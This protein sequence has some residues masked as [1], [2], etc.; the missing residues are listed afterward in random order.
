MAVIIWKELDMIKFTINVAPV[1]KKNHGQIIIN[2]KTGRPMVIPSPQYIQYEKDCGWFMPKVETIEEPV[3]VKAVFYMATKRKVDLVNLQEA[4]LD[5]LVKYGILTDDNSSVVYSMDG[6]YVD[7][8]KNR[9]RT[10]VF[11]WPIKK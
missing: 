5:V 1:T 6:S 10:E 2:K 8:D 9:P 11:I 4:L 3:N 7:Y